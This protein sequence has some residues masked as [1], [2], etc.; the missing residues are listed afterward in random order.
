MEDKIKS[1]IDKADKARADARRIRV[2]RNEA[3]SDSLALRTE[4]ERLEALLTPRLPYT[5]EEDEEIDGRRGRRG[6]HLRELGR[7]A[8][9]EKC[10]ARIELVLY[11]LVIAYFVM[12]AHC[13]CQ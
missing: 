4:L 12:Y 6:G 2:E 8:E 9:H 3:R 11:I 1:E 7:R 13:A 10:Y 5:Y